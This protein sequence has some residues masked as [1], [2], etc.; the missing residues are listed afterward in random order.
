MCSLNRTSLVICEGALE[1]NC[2]DV[3][4]GG[5]CGS[6]AVQG[7][8]PISYCSPTGAFTG[9][10]YE[11]PVD[12]NDGIIELRPTT[13]DPLTVDCRALGLSGCDA[14]GCTP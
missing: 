3:H 14:R 13:R 8:L 1:L 9:G 10:G 7:E 4:E 12:C 5:S 6:F 11:T 2:G